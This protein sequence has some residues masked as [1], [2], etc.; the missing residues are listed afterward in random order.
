LAGRLAGGLAKRRA[1]L[2]AP[3]RARLAGIGS[4][5]PFCRTMSVGKYP[6]GVQQCRNYVPSFASLLC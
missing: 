4:G 2:R 5:P 3:G 6:S 1:P